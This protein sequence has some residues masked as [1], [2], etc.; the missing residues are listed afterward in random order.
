[1]IQGT[2]LKMCPEGV[3][4]IFFY[5]KVSKSY[6]WVWT[7]HFWGKNAIVGKGETDQL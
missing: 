3:I 5:L 4:I 7:K 1:M 2:S 6:N